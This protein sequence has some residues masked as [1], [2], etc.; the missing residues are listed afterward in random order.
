MREIGKEFDVPVI[1]MHDYL[2]RHY[3]DGFLWWDFVHMTS[4]GQKLFAKY[5]LQELQPLLDEVIV[6]PKL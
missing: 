5:L 4:F 3:D 2:S 6:I 1:E